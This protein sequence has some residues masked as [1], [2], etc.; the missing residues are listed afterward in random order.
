M[1]WNQVTKGGGG[2]GTL[3]IVQGGCKVVLSFNRSQILIL[4]YSVAENPRQSCRK[5]K[6]KEKVKK[7]TE[8]TTDILFVD[9]DW[10]KYYDS[11]QKKEASDKKKTNS[12]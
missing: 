9:F 1:V 11:W 7:K 3:P 5:T 6:T 8:N 2:G 12:T 4:L 10:Q